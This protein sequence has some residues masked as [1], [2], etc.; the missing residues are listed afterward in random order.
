[1]YYVARQEAFLE[2][3]MSF[4]VGRERRLDPIDLILRRCTTRREHD[5][6]LLAPRACTASGARGALKYFSTFLMD[7]RHQLERLTDATASHQQHALFR[8]FLV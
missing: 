1:M 6:L 3:P 2:P 5:V 7:L 4:R 8:T